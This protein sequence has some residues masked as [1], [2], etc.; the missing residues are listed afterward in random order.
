MTQI[1]TIQKYLSNWQKILRLQN[2]NVRLKTVDTEYLAKTFLS[3]AG[4]NKE[5][6]FGRIQQ[7]VDKELRKANTPPV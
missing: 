5:I 3:L 1:Q 6:S 2:W 4:E 7:L